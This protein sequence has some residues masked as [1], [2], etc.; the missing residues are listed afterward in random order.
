MWV[1]PGVAD[2]LQQPE[3]PATLKYIIWVLP[4]AAF[5]KRKMQVSVGKI[6]QMVI[7]KPALLEPLQ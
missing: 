6:Y 2:P 1:L 3:F 4:V 5:G 7:L